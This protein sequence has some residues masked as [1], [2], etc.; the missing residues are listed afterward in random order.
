MD[1][2]SL[3]FIVEPTKFAYSSKVLNIRPNRHHQFFNCPI[4]LPL[5]AS[6]KGKEDQRD[7]ERMVMAMENCYLG[8]T[9]EPNPSNITTMCDT[10]HVNT[11]RRD[12]SYIW[13]PR[14]RDGNDEQ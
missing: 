14:Q 5:L 12:G 7:R 4:P 3:P 2:T 13:R 9:S 10:T 1:I 8:P 11:E 6:S